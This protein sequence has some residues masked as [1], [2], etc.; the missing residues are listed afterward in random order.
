M[1]TLMRTPLCILSIVLL[2]CCQLNPAEHAAVLATSGA[3]TEQGS[4]IGNSYLFRDVVASFSD[5]WDA[6]ATQRRDKSSH[7]GA[8]H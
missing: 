5:Q 4:S 6:G 3:T 8:G 2:D 7:R 1:R